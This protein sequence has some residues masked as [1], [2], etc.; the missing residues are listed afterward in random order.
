MVCVCVCV[1]G[2]RS[3]SSVGNGTQG[4]IHPNQAPYG[5]DP[6]S[7][8]RLVLKFILQLKQAYKS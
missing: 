6:I 1:G 4:L 8:P 5:Q 2:Y 3:V 7:L